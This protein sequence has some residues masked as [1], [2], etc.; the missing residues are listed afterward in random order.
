MGSDSGEDLAEFEDTSALGAVDGY[1]KFI[2]RGVNCCVGIIIRLRIL[3][4][5]GLIYRIWPVI[6][7]SGCGFGRILSELVP[8][9]RM[10]LVEF[11]WLE[12]LFF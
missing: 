4:I 2:K 10:C 3:I 1:D 5:I 11:W 12:M 9:V 7:G 8:G 6:R